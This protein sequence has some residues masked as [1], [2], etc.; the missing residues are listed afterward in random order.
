[1]FIQTE[2]A[3]NPATLKF[4]PGKGVLGDGSVDYRSKAEA[5][6]SPLATRT[7][8]IDGVTGVSWARTSSL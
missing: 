2:R 8:E 6:A 1:M 5:T 4:I 3:P 7:F